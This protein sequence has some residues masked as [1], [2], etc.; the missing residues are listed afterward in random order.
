MSAC[1]EDFLASKAKV[2][3][4]AGLTRIPSLPGRLFDWQARCVEWALRQGQ[5]ALFEDCGM[6]K[7][8]QQLA[9]ADAVVRERNVNALVLTPLAVELDA[10]AA[11][12]WTAAPI[13]GGRETSGKSAPLLNPADTRQQVGQVTVATP[14]QVGDILQA[15]IKRWADVIARAKIEKK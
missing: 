13:L 1:Y 9:W 8:G 4:P 12:G 14:E 10:A 11:R 15:D 7:T 3:P 5:A 2:R 6:G